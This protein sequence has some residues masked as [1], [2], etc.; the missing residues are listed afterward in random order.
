MRVGVQFHPEI[1]P[2]ILEILIRIRGEGIAGDAQR[3]GIVDA[4]RH[5]ARLIDGLAGWDARPGIRL[6]DNFA[7]LCAQRRGVTV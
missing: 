3:S 1:T 7:A 5:A 2:A 4:S 6:L